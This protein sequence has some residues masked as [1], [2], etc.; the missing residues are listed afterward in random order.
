MPLATTRGKEFAIK[1]LQQR[2]E[3][4]KKRKPVENQKLQAG[5]PMYFDCIACNASISVPELYVTKP[6]L[7]KECAALKELG[8]LE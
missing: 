8:W 6:E 5:S 7:C 4:N 2:R 3:K 1:A